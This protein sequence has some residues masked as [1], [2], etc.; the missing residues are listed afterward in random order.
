MGPQ[1]AVRRARPLGARSR[2]GLP[3]PRCLHREAHHLVHAELPVRVAEA[4]PVH[5]GR[6]VRE[7]D[8]VGHAVADGELDGVHVVAQ[9]LVDRVRVLDDAL[10]ERVG[11][12]LPLLHVL[13]V[14]RVVLDRQDHLAADAQA[15]HVLVE[16]DE[17]LERHRELPRLVVGREQLAHVVDLRDVLP[18]AAVCRLQERGELDVVGDRLPIERED[19]VAQGLLLVDRGDVVLLGEEQRARHRHPE[20]AGQRVAEE[21][22]VGGPPQRIGDDVRPGELRRLQEEPIEGDLVRQPVDDDVVEA[23]EALGHAAEL[24]Q[25]RVELR[26]LVHLVDECRREVVFHPDDEADSVGHG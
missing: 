20:L 1:I 17:L 10:L 8:R 9:R 6:R 15:A 5:V 3:L 7:V 14:L 24:D 18:A 23:V 4:P 26:V 12:E 2:A 11:E 22:G 25:L 21:L 19:E 13:A 16:V